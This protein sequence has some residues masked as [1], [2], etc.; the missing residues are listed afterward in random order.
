MKLI[1]IRTPI[2][3]AKDDLF[4]ILR[5]A[6]PQVPERS[7][8]VITSKIVALAE[9]AVVPVVTGSKEEKHQVVAQEA[10]QYIDPSASK[11][12]AMLAIRHGILSVNAGVDMSNAGNQYVLLPQHPYE[13]AAK[14]WHWLRATYGLQEVG[15]LIT[16]SK[17][18]PL[19]WGTMGTALAHAGFKGLRNMIGETDLFGYQMSMTQVNIAEGLAA[20]AVLCMGEVSEQT[21]LCLA[22][23]IPQIEFQDHPPSPQDIQDLHIAIEDDVYAPILTTADWKVR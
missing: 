3:H 2:V 22:E 23:E 11:Y 9:N 14:I 19:K 21:P 18:F 15:V 4:T 12:N 6:L 10:E 17:T 5:A 13:S 7:V 16:D 1:A 8:V 20:A